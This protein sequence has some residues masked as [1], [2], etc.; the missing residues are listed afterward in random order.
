M[1]EKDSQ[2]IEIKGISAKTM[3]LLLDCIYSEEIL[4]NIENV[5]EILPA[6]A[7]LQLNGFFYLQLN[8]I[9]RLRR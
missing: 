5:Q 6:A 1:K 8:L 2:I 3:E 4:L 7:L 9:L